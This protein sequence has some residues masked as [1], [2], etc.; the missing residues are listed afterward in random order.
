MLLHFASRLLLFLCAY[1]AAYK[2]MV[3]MDPCGEVMTH[4]SY[5]IHSNHCRFKSQPA[6]QYHVANVK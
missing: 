6:Q 1:M 4:V 2:S 3:S 5:L